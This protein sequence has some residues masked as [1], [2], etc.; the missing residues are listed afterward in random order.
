MRL[1]KNPLTAEE[2]KRVKKDFFAECTKGVDNIM[3]H[4]GCGGAIRRGFMNCFKAELKDDG[5]ELDP[6]EDGFGIGPIDVPYC[7]NCDPPDGFN[8]TYAIRVGIL[9][10][11]QGIIPNCS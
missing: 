4:N 9:P 10:A 11:K 8:Y 2:F 3:R 1:P 7:E 5:V 6:G